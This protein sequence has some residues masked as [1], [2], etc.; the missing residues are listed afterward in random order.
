[1][2]IERNWKFYLGI[3]LFIYSW[4][5]FIIVLILP[6]LPLSAFTITTLAAG[7]LISAE[8]SFIASAA[9]L[10]KPFVVWL[11]HKIKL[12]IF[13]KKKPKKFIKH[14]SKK[15]HIIGISLLILSALPYYITELALIFG[16][17][18]H[19]G[20]YLLI[21]IMIL[22][23]IMLIASLLI[24]GAEFWARLKLLFQWPGN[25]KATQSKTK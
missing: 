13:K 24:L 6:F 10:G 3:G 14:I 2:I 9:I 20:P 22:G 18:K 7:F 12:L 8:L 25:K 19:H 23:D 5:P 4:L 11:K 15:R 1:M 17:T 21:A 16:Y